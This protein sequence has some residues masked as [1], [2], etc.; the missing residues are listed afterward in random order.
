MTEQNQTNNAQTIS[1]KEEKIAQQKAK[2]AEY[3]K[4]WAK[5]KEED[6]KAYRKQYNE[7]NKEKR[8]ARY[9]RLKQE[10][11]EYILEQSRLYRQRHPEKIKARIKVY[12]DAHKVHRLEYYKKRMKTDPMFAAKK[13]LRDAVTSSFAR[14][15]QNK[16]A[17]T[18]KLLGCS[19]EEAKQHIE[20]LWVE[21]MS[22]DNHGAGTDC[23]HI[24]HIRP[25]AS[26]GED[27]LHLMN[28][29]ENLQPLW[30]EDN[31]RKK[32]KYQS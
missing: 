1:S 4:K 18:E 29:I 28:L 22:W 32:D 19:W 15:K 20:A 3:D 12:N 26:F 17:N 9:E 24:D 5:K 10:D 11:P 2:K 6:L 7:K 25:V 14:I 21:G 31:L 27:D 16:P 8:K 30:S 23:W 13:K